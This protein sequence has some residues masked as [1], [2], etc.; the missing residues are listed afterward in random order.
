MLDRR[1]KKPQYNIF[2]YWLWGDV[3][4]VEEYDR[5]FVY[6][7]LLKCY[8]RLHSMTKCKVACEEQKIDE[9]S[10]LDLFEQTTN[11]SKGVKVLQKNC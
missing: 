5:Q 11:T 2:F 7:M 1:F 3:N 10:N 6:F 8:H 4:I 9:H